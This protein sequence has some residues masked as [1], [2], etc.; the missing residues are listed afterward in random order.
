MQGT[1]YIEYKYLH[2]YL[3]GPPPQSWRRACI[4]HSLLCAGWALLFS[5]MSSL[6]MFCLIQLLLIF[7]ELNEIWNTRTAVIKRTAAKL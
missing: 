5:F 2:C 3:R 4:I 6:F 7:T 1:N